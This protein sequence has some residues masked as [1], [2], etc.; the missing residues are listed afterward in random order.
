MLIQRITRSIRM[1]FGFAWL[2]GVVAAK[3][4]PLWVISYLITPLSLLVLFLVWGGQSL[5][6]NADIG[7]LVSMAAMNGVGLMG[8]VAYYKNFVKLQDMMVASPMGA[9][10]YMLGLA[11]SGFLFS[12]PGLLLMLLFA[13]KLI[14]VSLASLAILMI[15]YVLLLLSTAGIGFT[16]A[17]FVREERYVWP[18]SNILSFS[19]MILPP[20]Y[21]PYTLLPSSLVN[22]TVVIPTSN[23][24][25]ILQYTTSLVEKV[26]Y[27][28]LV[29]LGILGIETIIFLWISLEK[30]QWRE[31]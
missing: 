29:L 18:L 24:A 26:P 10:Q 15:V 31:K 14:G 7:G 1:I 23:A 2:N 5:A 28:P 12:L 27:H 8:D 3:R 13:G 4:N 22:I 9:L 19:L 20:V 25:M 16:I 17:T 21:Y 6:R 30:S 11:L